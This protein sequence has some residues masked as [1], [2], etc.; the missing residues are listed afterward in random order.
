MRLFEENPDRFLDAA[1]NGISVADV[2]GDGKP[3]IEVANGH[4]GVLLGN[5]DGAFQAE[6]TY[7]SGGSSAVPVTDAIGAATPTCS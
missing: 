1:A 4:V 6:R 2:S 5:G 3:D 7:K